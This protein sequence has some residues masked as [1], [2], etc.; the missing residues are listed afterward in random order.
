MVS[1]L[2]EKII[3]TI[4]E[5]RDE[6][7]QLLKDLIRIPSITGEEGKCQEFVAK[8]LE[9]IGI[10][11]D[12]WQINWEELKKHPAYVPIETMGYKGYEGRPN[13]VGILKGQKEHPSLII[14]G[15][16]DVVPIGARNE[17]KHDPWGG[18]IEGNFIF[19][20]GACDMKAGIAAMI[21]A[22]A[23]LVECNVKLK[24]TLYIESVVDEEAGGNGTLACVIRGYKADAGII[25]EPTS[26]HYLCNSNRGA[27]FFRIKIE[28]GSGGLELKY[29]IPEAIEKAFKIYKAVDDFAAM[30]QIDVKHPLFKAFPLPAKIPTG[31]CKIQ[32]GDWPSTIP[33]TCIMEGS[34]ECLPGEDIREV[35]EQ[36]KKYIA[37]VAQTDPWLKRKP[38]E[39]EWFGLWLEAAETPV[40]HPIVE[41]IKKTSKEI[42]NFEP[43]IIGGGGSDLRLLNLY[44]DTPS[45][46]YGPGGGAMHGFDEYADL[47]QLIDYTKNLTVTIVR[48]CGAT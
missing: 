34:L 48:W 23:T 20:R 44:A 1:S 18:E 42:L 33:G 29:T 15:H 14:N 22:V 47:K 6:I 9:E 11:V 19:G 43:Q 21:S 4:D 36:F 45:V 2:E 7:I 17:W 28:G 25:A 39:V 12:K 27:Q 37:F 3:K 41:T 35:R 8:K 5:R 40:N 31:I 10:E 32:A 26:L 46:L 16:T 24:G 13:V 38:P 30:R